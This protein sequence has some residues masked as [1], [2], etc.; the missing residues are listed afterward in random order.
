[1]KNLSLEE[2]NAGIKGFFPEL[3][4]IE[5]TKITKEEV[6]GKIK[7][8]PELMTS[9]GFQYIEGRG[10]GCPRALCQPLHLNQGCNTA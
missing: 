1:M 3:A 5:F 7:L 9:N 6:I 8:M 4:G 2:C 10:L